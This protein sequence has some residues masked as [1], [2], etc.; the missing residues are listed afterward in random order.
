MK[1][2]SIYF[3]SYLAFIIGLLSVQVIFFRSWLPIFAI[4][5]PIIVSL[6][7]LSHE[8]F[9]NPKSLPLQQHHSVVENLLIQIDHE[10]MN[11]IATLKMSTENLED[12]GYSKEI[13]KTMTTALHRLESVNQQ[14]GRAHV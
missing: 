4:V 14:I 1:S 12:E 9:F 11:P 8:A 13:A 6:I 2:R 10:I 7:W 5:N 3:I